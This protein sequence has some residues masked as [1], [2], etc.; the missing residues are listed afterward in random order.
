MLAYAVACLAHDPEFKDPSDIAELKQIEKCLL[1]IL[2]PLLANNNSNVGFYHTILD[3]IKQHK[4]A[5]KS[6]EETINL[7]SYCFLF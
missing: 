1:L 5:Y 2:D 4:S 3:R 6:E 7:V